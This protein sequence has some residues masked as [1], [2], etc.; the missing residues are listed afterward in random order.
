MRTP[1]L[2]K[3]ENSEKGLVT[4]TKGS[5]VPT[6]MGLDNSGKLQIQFLTNAVG[7]T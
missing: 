7:V 3:I 2:I 5:S 6:E 4:A 1:T